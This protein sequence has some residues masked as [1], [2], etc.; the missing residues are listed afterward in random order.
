MVNEPILYVKQG[1][2]WCV[3][4]LDYFARKEIEMEVVDVR[5]DPSRMNELLEIS[6][7]SKTPTLKH[8]DFV[9]ADFDLDE[10]EAALAANPQA[11]KGLGFG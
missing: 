5:T 6:G 2:P 11:A 7:Q 8:G 4:A 3:D 10:F 9:V 1:C